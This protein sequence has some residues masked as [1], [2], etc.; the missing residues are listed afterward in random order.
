MNIKLI[1]KKAGIPI[2]IGAFL[3]IVLITAGALGISVQS[4][5]SDSLRRVGM[6]GLLVLAMVP[7]IKSGT[8][9]NFALPVGIVVGLFALVC[10]MEWDLMGVNLLLVSCLLAA[11]FCGIVGW[12]YGKMLNA[13]KGAEMTI[14]TYAGFSATALFGIVWLAAPFYNKKMGWMLGNGLRETI[15]MDAFDAA[16]LLSNFLGFE[17]A[18]IEIPTGML[19]FFLL[20]CGLMSLFF[21]TKAGIAIYAG[22]INPRF[23]EA[24]GL[25]VNRTRVLAN[26]IS[27]ILAGVGI[28]IYA[29]GYGYAQ[30][31]TNPLT[32]AF[33][34]VAAVLIGGATASKANCVNVVI[35]VCLFQTLLTSATPVMNNL[36]AGTDLSEMMR[37]IIQNGVILYALTQVKGGSR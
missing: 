20:C 33:P 35:G 23:A 24:A 16:Q 27:T 13:V 29:Q 2:I 15:Q 28:I 21:K 18:G 4:L 3:V 9:P 11:L 25:N 19:L 14:A 22:G 6:N 32:M 1:L 7:A 8:G 17:V 12:A 30:L 36:F 26:V 34:A 10:C 5:L 31:Y 37:M